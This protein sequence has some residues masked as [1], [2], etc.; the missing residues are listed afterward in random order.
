[1][2]HTLC[3]KC[4]TDVGN[5]DYYARVE[6]TR[7]VRFGPSIFLDLCPRCMEEIFKDI[8]IKM[9]DLGAIR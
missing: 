3:D 8:Q 7:G 9:H 1:M 4:K 5:L 2:T 6:I